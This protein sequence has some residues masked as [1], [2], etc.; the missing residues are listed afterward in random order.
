MLH[1]I[2]IE[3]HFGVPDTAAG[4][5]IYFTGKRAGGAARL[6]DI[7]DS[8]IIEMDANGMDMMV[9]SL[10]SPAIQE[11][12]DVKRAVAK[13]EVIGVS[14]F[15]N[16]VWELYNLNEDFNERNNLAKKY[17]E[18]LEELKK[19][20]DEQAKENNLYPLIDWQDVYGRRIHNTGASK[21]K[22]AQELIQQVTKPGE[23][24]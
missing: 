10:N 18:K 8:R 21:G 22:T 1:K 2:G 12:Y 24:K 17:P 16:D 6:M 13:K 7:I 20:F 15:D 3:E 14:N 9:L 19:L 4:S 11:I 5:D 23:N